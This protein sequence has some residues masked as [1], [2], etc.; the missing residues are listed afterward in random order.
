[1]KVLKYSKYTFLNRSELIKEGSE[2]MQ[3]QF[4]IEPMGTQGGGGQFAFAQD[5]SSSYYNYQ[6]SPYTDFYARQSGLVA[7]LDR[8]MKQVRGQ[9]GMIYKEENPFLEDINDYKNLKILRMFENNNLK[10]DVFI[11]Y[12]YREEEFFGVLK[13]F[14]SLS[15]PKFESEIF[16][17]PEYQYR[18]DVEYKLRLG[19]YF[20]K[21]L[22]KWFIPEKGLYKNL[23][24]DNRVKNKMGELYEMK[25]NKVVEVL[26]YNKSASNTP[27]VILK[28]KGDT[29]HIEGN[30]YFFFKWRFEKLNEQIV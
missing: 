13:N 25:S 4:G 28:Y 21:K 1:M 6:D 2:F 14:N 9:S 19:N 24:E 7:N 20:Y 30:D 22:E 15:K 8:V 29:F 17:T 16:Y 5:P 12:E 3:F 27:Y 11:S 18:F 10:L 26:G 23:K